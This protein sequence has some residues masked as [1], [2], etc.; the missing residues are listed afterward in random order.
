MVMPSQI[1]EDPSVKIEH[2]KAIDI[3]K[4]QQESKVSSERLPL[5]EHT[6]ELAQWMVGINSLFE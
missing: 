6:K 3:L 2:Y 5:D 1:K 4:V